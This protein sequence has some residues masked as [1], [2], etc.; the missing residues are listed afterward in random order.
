MRYYFSVGYDNQRG[1]EKG[2]SLDRVTSRANLDVDLRKNLLLSFG[3]DGSV[4][5]AK[6]NHSSIQVFDEAY[7]RRLKNIQQGYDTDWL[8]KQ[9]MKTV[10]WSISINV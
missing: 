4:Q 5:K 6:Y 8:W 1:T 7:N 9:G 2:V 10:N 3:M